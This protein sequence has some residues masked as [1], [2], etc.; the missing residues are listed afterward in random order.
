L[1]GI[2]GNGDSPRGNN[3]C[4]VVRRVEHGAQRQRGGRA[5]ARAGPALEVSIDPGGRTY[6][7]AHTKGDR[8]TVVGFPVRARARP[9]RAHPAPPLA[10]GGRRRLTRT[11]TSSGDERPIRDSRSL[12]ADGVA[13]ASVFALSAAVCAPRAPTVRVVR[14]LAVVRVYESSLKRYRQTFRSTKCTRRRHRCRTLLTVVVRARVRARPSYRRPRVFPRRARASLVPHT[15]GR[16]R[17]TMT[18]A[19]AVPRR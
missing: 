5:S 2:Y 11:H 9:V 18:P 8:R 15:H 10:R 6:A 1:D 7:T 16:T 4:C 12:P 3:A 19:A 14:P 13:R 17:A